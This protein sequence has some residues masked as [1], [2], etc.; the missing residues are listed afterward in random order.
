MALGCWKTKKL[1]CGMEGKN[2][3]A[4][5]R[6]PYPAYHCYA[7]FMLPVSSVSFVL[8]LLSVLFIYVVCINYMILVCYL[9]ELCYLWYIWVYIWKGLKKSRRLIQLIPNFDAQYHR[10]KIFRNSD[11][12]WKKLPLIVLKKLCKITSVKDN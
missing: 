11:Y 5:D 9:Y 1:I 6:L 8:S 12:L 3:V 2:I 7:L 10:N 4:Y